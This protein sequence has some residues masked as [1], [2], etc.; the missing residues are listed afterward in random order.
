[1]KLSSLSVMLS[2]ARYLPG[3]QGSLFQTAQGIGHEFN[4]ERKW[5]CNLGAWKYGALLPFRTSKLPDLPDSSTSPTSS[6]S[7]LFPTAK[8]SN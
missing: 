3:S 7:P 8:E 1:M 4:S 5:P 2:G 6:S